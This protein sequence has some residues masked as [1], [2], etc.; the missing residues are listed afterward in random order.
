MVSPAQKK[1]AVA[2]VVDQRLCSERRACRYLGVHR[3][4]YRY[5][6]KSPLPQQVQ[7]H[8][9]IVSLSWQYP[10][11]GYRRIRA[12]LEREGWSV[13]RKQVQRIRRKEGLK[14][15]PKPQRISRQGVST[16]LP[17]QATH[18][19]HVWTWDFIFDRTDKGS[20]LKML[21]MLD[22]YTRQCLA[23]RVERQIR[24]GQVLATLW[25][26]MMQY[27]IPE[28]IRSDNGTE[29]IAGKIQRWL[30]VNQI[31]TLYIE[32]GSPWQN[33]YI[34]SFHSRFRDECLNRE[35]LLN[36]REA[37]VVIEDWRQHYNTERPHSRLGYLSPENYIK[38]QKVSP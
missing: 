21:T 12:V 18:R 11:Y 6:V 8:Q 36:L 4:T 14:V 37:R 5:P 17:T 28:H 1:Q 26:A 15:H 29:F 10:R 38:H 34:E 30:R 35:W 13:S 31:K 25:Q 20:T 33:G 16:G 32:P 7:L 2:Y 9:R 3:S 27:G 19:N 24:S 22:E 23:I